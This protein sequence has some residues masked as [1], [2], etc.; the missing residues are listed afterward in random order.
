MLKAPFDGFVEDINVK[1][2]D[3]ISP[4]Q[5]CGSI[6]QLDPMIVSGEVT[7]KNIVQMIPDQ[8]VSIELLDGKKLDG[9]ISYISKSFC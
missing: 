6:I 2:G 1:V 8:K 3:L 7:E 5:M 9:Q 4:S